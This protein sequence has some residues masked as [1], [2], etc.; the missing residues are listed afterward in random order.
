MG[1]ETRVQLIPDLGGSIRSSPSGSH[2]RREGDSPTPDEAAP[3]KPVTDAATL[4][5]HARGSGG[6][7]WQRGH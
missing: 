3:P 2:L 4:A 5:P 1:R 7:A 6:L